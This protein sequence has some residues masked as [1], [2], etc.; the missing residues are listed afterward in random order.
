MEKIIIQD[1]I[2]MAKEAGKFF[3]SDKIS[4][5]TVKGDSDFATAVDY[6]VSDFL[7]K[8][9]KEKYP[10]ARVISEE[11][12]GEDLRNFAGGVFIVDPVD[13]TTNLIHNMRTSAVS[14]GYLYCGEPI[15]GVVYNPFTDECFYGEKGQG[16]YLNGKKLSVSPCR[17]IKSSLVT[18]GTMPYKKFDA[19]RIFDIIKRIYMSC[20]D[21]RRSGSSALDICYVAEGRTEGFS[22][23]YLC[24]WDY[25]A[26]SV[27]LKEAGGRISSITGADVD[28]FANT[29]ILAT[30]NI[31]H[32][33]LIDIIK[34]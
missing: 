22:E 32:S 26:A 17:D 30:N 33:T 15:L 18:I 31:L 2:G 19:D 10:S 16:S 3:F 28:Y 24:P 34:G 13:G 4:E 23:E 8:A 7:C 6:A 9:L 14:I 11:G 5:I 1:I 29:D 21:I 25:A 20:V 12:Q 27:I